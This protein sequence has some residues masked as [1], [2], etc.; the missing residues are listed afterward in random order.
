MGGKAQGTGD[1]SDDCAEGSSSAA[2]QAEIYYAGVF[3]TPTSQ[4]LLRQAVAPRHPE[5][6]ADHVTLKFKPGRDACLQL[7]LGTSILIRVTGLASTTEV[8]VRAPW[9]GRGRAAARACARGQATGGW[10]RK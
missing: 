9:F 5:V 2:E 1:A 6:S 4:R 8:Q 7:P 3:L 10:V